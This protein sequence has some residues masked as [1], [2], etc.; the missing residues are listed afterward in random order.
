MPYYQILQ[1][2]SQKLLERVRKK[3]PSENGGDIWTAYGWLRPPAHIRAP[4]AGPPPVWTVA[5]A[6]R[7]GLPN[8]T[9]LALMLIGTARGRWCFRRLPKNW[10]RN[11]TH[12]SSVDMS[13]LTLR[14]PFEAVESSFVASAFAHVVIARAS[15]S[16]SQGAPGG[17]D[18]CLTRVGRCLTRR[19]V[20]SPSQSW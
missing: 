14:V 6:M 13:M 2:A 1:T 16:L 12:F 3:S 17:R 8:G 7:R 9:R 19:C 15:S 5:T 18:R 4:S 10:R 20:S 11:V